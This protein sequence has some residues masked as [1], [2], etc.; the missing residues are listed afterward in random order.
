MF[1]I[2]KTGLQDVITNA[3]T[4]EH[5]RMLYDSAR[6]LVLSQLFSRCEFEFRA[7]RNEFRINSGPKRMPR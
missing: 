3:K 4:R 7:R 1:E 2:G 5:F 6:F